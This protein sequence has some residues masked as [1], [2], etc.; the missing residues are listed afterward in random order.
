MFPCP[1]P[2]PL[3]IQ[4]LDREVWVRTRDLNDF[5]VASRVILM[6]SNVQVLLY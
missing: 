4:N 6:N 5:K 2:N 1:T 3:V